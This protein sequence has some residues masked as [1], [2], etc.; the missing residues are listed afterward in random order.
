MNAAVAASTRRKPVHKVSIPESIVAQIKAQRGKLN[1]YDRLLGPK[2]ALVVI[3]LQNA[4]MLPGM[5]TEVKTARDIV[6]N[7]NRLAKAVRAAHGKVVWVKIPGGGRRERW[8]VFYEY[9][10]SPSHSASEHRVLSRD[11]PGH[12]L[13][14]ELEPLP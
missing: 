9:F 7:V 14:S 12:A 8:S 5:P 2:T 4:F 13:Y 6:P 10:G 3:D 11:D 1:R